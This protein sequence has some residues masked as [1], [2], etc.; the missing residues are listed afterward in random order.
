M[1]DLNLGV[2]KL[3]HL[4]WLLLVLIV[5]CAKVPTIGENGFGCSIFGSRT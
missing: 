1:F 5:M 3:Q 2:E 4:I